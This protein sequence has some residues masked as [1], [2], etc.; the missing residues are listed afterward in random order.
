[1]S[2]DADLSREHFASMFAR[3][4]CHIDETVTCSMSFMPAN[5]E[6][7]GLAIIQAMNH[8]LHVERVNKN[9]RQM[10]QCRITTADYEIPPYFPGFSSENHSE[11]LAETEWNKKDIVLQIEMKHEEFIVRYGDAEDALKELT[12]ADGKTINPEKVGCMTGTLI[13]MFATGG[14]IDSDNCAAFDWFKLG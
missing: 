13:G 14:G 5:N 11:I 1:M 3:R 2:F 10:L 9:G 6:S 8:Q 4:Q 12:V 7:A